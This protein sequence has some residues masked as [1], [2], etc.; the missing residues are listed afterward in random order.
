MKIKLK[1]IELPIV[2]AL[3]AAS[4]GAAYAQNTSTNTSWSQNRTGERLRDTE[5][6]DS[7]QTA[8]ASI[9][10]GMTVK[11]R[12][13]ETIGEV[14]D[15]ALDLHSG[16][17]LAVIVSSGGFL[18]F[19]GELSAVAPSALQ[20]SGSN[21]EIDASKESLSKGPHFKAD[22]WPDFAAPGYMDEVNRAYRTEFTQDGQP[23]ADNSER[24]V[25]DRQ[26][27]SVTPID[28]GSSKDDTATTAEIRKAIVAEK[29]LSLN[30]Q[31]VKIVTR[32]GHVT[33]RGP[34]NSEQE[35]AT[36]ESIAKR[37]ASPET[38]DTQLEVKHT[39]AG[40]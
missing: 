14:K 18:G 9:V 40:R 4:L 2:A 3:C 8:K 10:M 20:L 19:G 34:V 17:V 39:S 22:Q 30:A 7:G 16:K 31:N 24:N 37:I 33:L 1:I 35:K 29:S 27:S 23:A 12:Q 15:L 26:N 13:G 36:I 25:R 5:M 21:L 32:N 28:Q 11:N 6:H 38:V